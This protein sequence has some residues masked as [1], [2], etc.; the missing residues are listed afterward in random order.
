SSDGT[1]STPDP[2]PPFPG[3]VGNWQ[4]CASQ[5]DHT[6][7]TV[8]V[9]NAVHPTNSV[10]AFEV[11]KRVAWLLRGEGAG[12]LVKTS[13]ENV[14]LWQ[15]FSCSASRICYPDGHVWKLIADAGPGGANSPGFGDNDFTDPSSYH[16]A[17]DP[18]KP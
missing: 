15:G 9:W 11:V 18:G 13:G 16:V 14:I 12:L 2:P 5:R 17:I 10:G 8:C 3:P 4:A 7:L 1:F 6:A